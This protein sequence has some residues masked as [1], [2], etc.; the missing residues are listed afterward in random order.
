MDNQLNTIRDQQKE[1]WNKFSGGWKKWNKF[2]MDFLKPMGDAIIQSLN[3][4]PEDIVLDIASGTGEPAFSI[5]RLATNGKVYATDL[6][7]KMLEVAAEAAQSQG[8]NNIEF[9]VAD[10]SSL[11][12]D[13]NFF[14]KVSCRMG[15]M[16]FPDMQLA[17][18][19]M[20]RVCGAGGKAASC[21]WAAA[22]NNDW[23]TTIM[24]ILA[25]NIEM[26]VPQPGS[27]G[28][29]RCAKPGMIKELFENAGFKNVQE[30]NIYGKL[31]YDTAEIYWQNMMDVAAP[32]VGALSK[33]D[34]NTR[35][36]IKNE[37]FAACNKKLI[38]G[39]LVL[40]YASTIIS[41]E[42]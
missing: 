29:F 22:A 13:D 37:V 17:A 10:V 14:D 31:D 16:F 6:S 7:D 4:Q 15:F 21:V 20:F 8:V 19:E 32:V 12:F 30:N 42:K 34:D 1:T 18:D 40:N 5:A 23:V 33:A 9:K 2:T 3:I 35:K 41:G 38:N 11:P 36:K 24:K 26:P 25:E 39:R 28:M 27:P